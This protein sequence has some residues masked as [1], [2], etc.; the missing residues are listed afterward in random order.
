MA[1]KE[2]RAEEIAPAPQPVKKQRSFLWLW[3]ALSAVSVILLLAVLH[4]AGALRGSEEALYA[5]TKDVPVLG[6]FTG[7]FHQEKWEQTLS[8]EQAI[9]VKDL[10]N[11]LIRSEGEIESLK[12]T[13][14]EMSAIAADVDSATR[15][16]KKLNKDVNEM[17]NGD[18][19]TPTTGGGA[20]QGAVAAGATTA[21]IPPGIVSPGGSMTVPAMG[22]GENYRLV[23]KIFEKLSPDTAVDILNNLSDEEKVK[24]LSQMKEKT[25]ADILGAFDPIK[26]A[27][28]TRM[29]AKS[30][31]T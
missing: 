24:I 30:A 3:I 15:N 6:F 23:S 27:T 20:G 26:S 12:R 21:S 13:I 10:R 16:I 22:S 9:D 2:V 11:K 5:S 29:I 4:L 18:M 14:G 19:T 25:V 1:K 8:P 28:L 7:L 31:G 17:K